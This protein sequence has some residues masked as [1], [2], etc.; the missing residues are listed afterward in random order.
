MKN[1]R[2]QRIQKIIDSLMYEYR[3]QNELSIST[4]RLCYHILCF[5]LEYY[6]QYEEG[7]I[8]LQEQKVCP[9]I[10]RQSLN[11][12]VDSYMSRKIK[13]EQ[14]NVTHKLLI[15]HKILD[16]DFKHQDMI[17]NFVSKTKHKSSDEIESFIKEQDKYW[18]N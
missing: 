14:K 3:M 18:L 15:S 2:E 16:P 1:P 17:S 6:H 7:Y 5:E 11:Y 9:N 12:A 10:V 8:P 13:N 4:K